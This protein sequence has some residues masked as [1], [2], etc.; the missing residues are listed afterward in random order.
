MLYTRKG[1]NGTTKTFGCDQRI[2]KSST[3]AEALGSLDEI[4]SF[5]GLCKVKSRKEK[6][7]VGKL[8]ISQ[9]VH[10]IQKNLFIVQAEL[11]G[12][13]MSIDEEKVKEL[14]MI[15]DFVEKELPPIKTFFISGGT[16]LASVFDIA[17][18]I[19]RRAERRVV[20]VAEEGK[21]LVSKFTLAYLNRLSSVLYAFARLANYK[22]GI[23]E[24]SPD[25]K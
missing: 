15:V 24:Q 14:E 21:I 7:L 8:E 20:G 18:T 6:F 10:D 1:D 22:E 11:A 3:I 13:S 17:R 4:N 12:A 19:S 23:T 5:L 16:E 2:S 25:Y 9:I